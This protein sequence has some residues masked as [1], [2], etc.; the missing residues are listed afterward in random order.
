[1]IFIC[2]EHYK[3]QFLAQFKVNFM[4]VP[5]FERKLSKNPQFYSKYCITVST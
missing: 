1:M 3:K 4:V 2:S 5:D